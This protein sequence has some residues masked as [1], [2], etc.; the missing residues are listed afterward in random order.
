MPITIANGRIEQD[1]DSV[2]GL[3]AMYLI[4]YQIAP[5]D[6]T[7]DATNTD[8]I[9][10][11]TNVDSLYKFDLRGE[12]SWEQDVITDPSAGTTFYKQKLAI[13][14]KKHDAATSKNLKL[15]AYSRPHIV[16][17]DNNGRFYIMGLTNGVD[18]T[19]GSIAQGAKMGD[20]SGY[21]LTL[22]ADE[23]CYANHLDAATEA[24]MVT[25]FTSATLVT[26]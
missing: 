24:A 16:I 1:K 18:V 4:N 7:Y 3:R 9:D 2:G 6:I 15:L 21:S 20:F 22:E 5:T 10:A 25:L 11:I 17:Q 8:M 23:K 13:R 14:L 12:N 19:G 26:S